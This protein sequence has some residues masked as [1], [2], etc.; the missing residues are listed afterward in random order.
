MVTSL[1]KQR[2]RACDGD[3]APDIYFFP[4]ACSLFF[5]EHAVGVFPF[6]LLFCNT[7]LK[8]GQQLFHRHSFA[9]V[10]RVKKG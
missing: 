7:N 1:F 10:C 3:L 9:F 8:V 5:N 2:L 6:S 4:S